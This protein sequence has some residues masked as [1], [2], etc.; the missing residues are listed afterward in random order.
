L[1]E[2]VV[3]TDASRSS[4][5]TS[6]GQVTCRWWWEKASCLRNRTSF[7]SLALPDYLP[8][9][10]LITCLASKF[11]QVNVHTEQDTGS[12]ALL[13]YLPRVNRPLEKALEFGSF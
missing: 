8:V 1:F 11:G 13:V 10:L 4:H 5:E 12:L 9:Y 7:Y 6:E 2:H 3:A